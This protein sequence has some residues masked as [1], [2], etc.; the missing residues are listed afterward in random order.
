MQ[1]TWYDYNQEKKYDISCMFGYPTEVPIYEHNICQSEYYDKH[2]KE[3]LEIL[4]DKYSLTK[5]QN[6]KK[7][8]MEEYYY[9]MSQS[10]I[11]MSP[12]GF[13]EMN[14]RDLV[15]AQIGSVL[16]EPD[17]SYIES[18]PFIYEDDETYIACKYDWSDLE[19]KID[20]VLNNYIELREYLVQNMRKKYVEEYE[21][22]K[23]A[24]HLYD[25]F[26]KLNEV[27]LESN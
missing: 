24:L 25:V 9:K 14:P 26:S 6:G 12:F 22:S 27:K 20:Y 1:P 18:K 3:L 17:M 21:Y 13:G 7:V 23:I 5:L 16:V 4:G 2:R 8:S 10:K 15:S 19:E 11:I